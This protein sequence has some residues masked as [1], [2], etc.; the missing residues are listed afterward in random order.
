MEPLTFLK[1]K[2]RSLSIQF[3]SVQIRYAYNN[4]IATHIVELTPENEYYNNTLLDDTWIPISIDFMEMFPGEN[5]SF[6]SSDSNL[7]IAKAEIEFNTQKMN[8]ISKV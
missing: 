4:S 2:L 3:R 1:E 6:I 7:A 5:I 8:L